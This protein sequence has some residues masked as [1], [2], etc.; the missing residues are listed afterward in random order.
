[1]A[2]IV[3]CVHMCTCVCAC[4]S[5]YCFYSDHNRLDTC[6]ASLR[7]AM[8]NRRDL[9]RKVTNSA[10]FSEPSLSFFVFFFDFVIPSTQHPIKLTSFSLEIVMFSCV[11]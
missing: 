2:G 7:L 4:Y 6:R 8:N 1:M 11:N 3:Q 9:K 5:R 10:A